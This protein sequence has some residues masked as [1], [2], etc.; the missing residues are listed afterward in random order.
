MPILII[1][2]DH[3]LFIAIDNKILP[4]QS[5]NNIEHNILWQYSIKCINPITTFEFVFPQKKIKNITGFERDS[6]TIGLISCNEI[7]L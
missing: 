7:I 4:V 5:P 6:K 3:I 2:W 1:S